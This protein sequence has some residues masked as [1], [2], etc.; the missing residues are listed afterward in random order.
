MLARE[1]A[2]SAVSLPAKNADS[3]RHTS[4]MTRESQSFA[5][6]VIRR[7]ILS[8]NRFHFSGSCAGEFIGQEGAHL[9]RIDVVL[10]EGLRRCR[11]PG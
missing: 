7:V 4:T 9:G 5:V 8:E 10:D 3:S 11:A 6:I 1:D 2:V